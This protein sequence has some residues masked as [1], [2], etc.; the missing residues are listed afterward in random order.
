MCGGALEPLR[1]WGE[2]LVY[3]EEECHVRAICLVIW[4]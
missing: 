2:M 1:A 3:G 4:Q